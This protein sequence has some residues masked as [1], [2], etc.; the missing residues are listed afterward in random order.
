MD[1]D[2]A[3][4]P[5]AEDLVMER[6]S[7]APLRP[8]GRAGEPGD[9]SD[10]A[11]RAA[12]T[13]TAD[14]E[15]PIRA[16]PV[17]RVGQFLRSLL[18]S[19]LTKR[20]VF[21][22]LAALIVLL[23]GILYLN[24]FREGLIAARVQSLTIQGRIIA[25]A[26]ASSATVETDTI[27]IDPDKLLELQAGESIAPTIDSF[28]TLDSPIKPEKVAPLLRSLIQPTRTRARI[29][30]RD[31]ILVLDS[32]HL[33]GGGQVVR[34]DLPP[35]ESND[36]GM[37]ATIGKTLNKWLQ[38]RDVPIHQENAIGT[39]YPEVAAA[40]IGQPST[41]TRMTEQGELIVSVAVPVQRLRA[42]L[43]V[44]LLSTQGGDIDRIVAEER[45]AIMRVFLVAGTVIIMLSFL[46]ASTIANPLRRLA[47]AAV[48]VRH[49]VKSR[50]QIPDFSSRHDEIGN[51]SQSLRDMTNA[52][53]ARIEAIESFAA[54]VSHELKNPLTS[55]RS[56]VETLPVAANETARK[57]L[58]AIIQHDVRRLDRLIT[59]ISDASRLDAELA[60]VDLQPVDLKLMLE[61]IVSMRR[62]IAPGT[63]NVAYRLHVA[64]ARA[65]GAYTVY[66]HESRIGQV[67]NN[68]LDN[69]RSFVPADTGAIDIGL[70]R[71]GGAIFITVEDNGPGIQADNIER[72]FER[73]YTD[74]PEDEGFGQN[75][76]LGLS[77]S[78][79][80]IEAH[81]G[82]IRAE[83]R[84][85]PATGA[86]FTITLPAADRGA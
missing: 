38:R 5:S 24:Q 27:M 75:S 43:G 17:A 64:P 20:I 44:L 49:G 86:R 16:R 47:E 71:R 73:F 84:T 61:N 72:I 32:R 77:I 55:L 63:K 62:L 74:R 21:L 4:A 79:Q 26:I 19:S 58:L 14:E 54:D 22:N 56:A 67:V 51:L 6:A 66:G 41:V 29:Y 46:L 2:T 42:V 69:A 9:R 31:G 85:P 13:D 50:V 25:G 52:L 80:I 70:R 76:G 33:Y 37:I 30:D 48:R 12:E 53:Y 65:S 81:D 68:L 10:V 39:D 59:D 60:R 83:N 78:R 3:R 1:V 15:R 23:S 34:Y 82:T 7:P 8:S 18:F 57:K 45:I 40:L 35:L 28:E 36:E 11:A